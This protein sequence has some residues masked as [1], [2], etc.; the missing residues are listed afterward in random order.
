MRFLMAAMR[1]PVGPGESYLTTELA[2]A[3]VEAGHEVEVL[4]L[5]WDSIAPGGVREMTTASGVRVVRVPAR[6]TRV[7]GP[8][9]HALKFLLSGRAAA[10]TARERFD[11]AG[12]DAFVAWM[13]AMAIAPLL[14]L[15]GG[16]AHRHLIVWD[17]FPD[18]YHEI[19]RIPRGPPLRIARA[20]EQR[21]LRRFTA[22]FCT[23][24]GTC[25]G[26]SAS[27]RARASP[28]CR[29]GPASGLNSRSI[30]RPSVCGTAFPP[31]RR[32]R[33]SAG[34]WLPVAASSRSSMP[35]A[36]RSRPVRRCGSC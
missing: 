18:H 25:G 10:R 35:R 17:V 22:I 13:P 36:S 28:R 34:R 5:D 9:G 30:A 14:P 3:L 2:E 4:H 12:F 21:A 31:R 29:S 26:G 20:L 6:V 16:I 7:R 1:Y 15:V 23:M 27:P 19:G 24:P 32:S 11:L 8:I 33:C